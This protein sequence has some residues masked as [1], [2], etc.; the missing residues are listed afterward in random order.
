MTDSALPP[1]PRFFCDKL[2]GPGYCIYGGYADPG[3]CGY[4]T[5][6]SIESAERL[7]VFM[8]NSK[9]PN[10]FKK[11][12]KVKSK[13]KDF[14]RFSKRFDLSQIVT[15]REYPV[16]YSLADEEVECIEKTT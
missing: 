5:L 13:A 14:F 16:E 3:I 11:L 6:D 7:L 1:A 8:S 2:N 4:V 12:M 9:I 10:Y 15:G